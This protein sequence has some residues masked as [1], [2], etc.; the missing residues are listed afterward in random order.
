MI[1]SR[2]APRSATKCDGISDSGTKQDGCRL[3]DSEG[4]WFKSRSRQFPF[5]LFDFDSRSNNSKYH[6]PSER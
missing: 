2:V 3:R 6:R 4:S 5:Y 1:G